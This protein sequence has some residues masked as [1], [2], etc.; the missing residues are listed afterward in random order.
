ML[1]IPTLMVL[2]PEDFCESKERLDYKMGHCLKKQT[3]KKNRKN[4]DVRKSDSIDL[5]QSPDL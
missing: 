5:R 4:L 2:R 3:N 1:V